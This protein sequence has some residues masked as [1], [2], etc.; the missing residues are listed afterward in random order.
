MADLHRHPIH[1]LFYHI[2]AFQYRIDPLIVFYLQIY[3][4]MNETLRI[5]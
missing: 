5:L 2:S 3:H 4:K 1:V